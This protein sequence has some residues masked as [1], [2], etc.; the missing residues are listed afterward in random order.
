MKNLI[1][2]AALSLAPF[3]GATT[4]AEDPKDAP[5]PTSAITVLL[6]TEGSKVGGTITFTKTD[7]GIHVEGQV[8]GLTEGKHGFHIHEFGD[9]TSTDGKSAGGHF[10]PT[11]EKHGGPTAEHRHEGDFG[12]IEAGSDGVAKVNF[13]D[14]HLTFEGDK[15]ILGR[16]VVIHAKADDLTTQPTGDA[17]GRVAVGVIGVSKG[18]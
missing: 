7:G 11:G 8:T 6:P 10:N 18:K 5:K 4:F 3:F 14:K 1:A 15:S 12:N 13:T 16:G 9:T 17:G 2:L